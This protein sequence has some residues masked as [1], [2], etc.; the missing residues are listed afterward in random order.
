M[1]IEATGTGKTTDDAI[2][3]LF[4]DDQRVMVTMEKD[5]C[6]TYEDREAEVNE[7]EGKSAVRAH[8]VREAPDVTKTD[9]GTDSSHDK[10]K[11]GAKPFTF[12]FHNFLSL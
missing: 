4:G 6:K 5:N 7:Q 1:R 8:L 12:V 10:T 9:G 11:V 3:D 2:R